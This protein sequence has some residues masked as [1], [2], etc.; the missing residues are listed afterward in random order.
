[1]EGQIK[2]FLDSNVLFSIAYTGRDTSRSHLIYE[3]QDLGALR[4]FLSDLVCEEALFNIRRKKPDAEEFLKEL[5]RRSEVLGDIS[6]DLQ[7]PETGQLPPNDRIILSTAVYHK[8]DVFVTGNEKDFRSLYRK[9]VLG[10]LILRPADFLN[11][12]F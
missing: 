8:M 5:I 4:V 10:T 9:R 3:I 2:V 11:M 12:R 1:M 7:H 6:A